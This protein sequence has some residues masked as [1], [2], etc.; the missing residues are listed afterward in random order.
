MLESIKKLEAS[1]EARMA[2]EPRRMTADEKSAL[3]KAY[4]PDYRA[5][6]ASTEKMASESFSVEVLSCFFPPIRRR[7][8]SPT[9]EPTMTSTAFTSVPNS[10]KSSMF[11][12]F[13]NKFFQ[14]SVRDG[15]ISRHVHKNRF[16]IVYARAIKLRRTVTSH[17]E[18]RG[19]ERI[20]KT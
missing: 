19:R 15:H 5:Q 6:S 20:G 10:L 8:P 2:T 11:L 16:K 1:R 13:R 9:S 18:E 4:H 14:K 3:L 17:H 7:T 12:S